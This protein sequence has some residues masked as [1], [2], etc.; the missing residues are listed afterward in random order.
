MITPPAPH[1]PFT[2]AARHNTTIFANVTAPRTPNFNIASRILDKH[3]LI[4]MPPSP[5]TNDILDRIDQY[6]RSRWQTLLA[7]DDLI[8][9]A[10]DKLHQLNLYEN[11]YV[12]LTSDH[13]F[14]LGQFSMPYDKRQPYETDIRIPFIVTGPDVLR[15]NHDI[16]DP[17]AL[18]DLAPTILELAKVKPSTTFDGQSFA[19]LLRKRSNAI[20]RSLNTDAVQASVDTPTER[21]FER[22]LLIEY[23]GEGTTESFNANCPWQ[24]RDRLYVGF[25]SF[26]FLFLFGNFESEGTFFWW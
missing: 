22:K 8:E 20:L 14:H 9:A 11:T 25:L 5:L 17:I 7:V 18:I 23:W 2:P 15:L 16:E 26:S 3:W 21:N 6:Y 19:D 24:K 4:R 13:G 10:I 1:A 12:I